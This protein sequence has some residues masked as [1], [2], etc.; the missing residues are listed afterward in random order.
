[1][2]CKDSESLA[3]SVKSDQPGVFVMSTPHGK[4]GDKAV[5]DLKPYLSKGDIIIDC[6]NEHYANTERR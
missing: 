3:K 1:M 5:D 2:E 4:P 6:A